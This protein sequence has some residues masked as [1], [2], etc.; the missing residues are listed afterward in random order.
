MLDGLITPPSPSEVASAA[1]FR[2]P[3][4][5]DG[6]EEVHEEEEKV[7]PILEVFCGPEGSRVERGSLSLALATLPIVDAEQTHWLESRSRRLLE[8]VESILDLANPTPPLYPHRHLV[9]TDQLRRGHG[10]TASEEQHWSGKATVEENEV[11]AAVFDCIKGFE[12]Y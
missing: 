12:R 5:N 10:W 7:V 4:S 11:E 1:S 2:G 9:K 6:E 3:T 8:A